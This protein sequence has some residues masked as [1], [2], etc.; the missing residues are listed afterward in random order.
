MGR[1]TPQDREEIDALAED[2]YNTVFHAL[3]VDYGGNISGRV[4]TAAEKAF[5]KAMEKELRVAD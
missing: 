1:I 2:L 4:A 3:D 5:K